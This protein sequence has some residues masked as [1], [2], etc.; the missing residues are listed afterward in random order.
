LIS[1]KRGQFKIST[2]DGESSKV[3]KRGWLK[4][5]KGE[6]YETGE[7]A[8]HRAHRG[9]KHSRS[10]KTGVRRQNTRSNA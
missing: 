4:V 6:L 10:Q 7:E 8:N 2:G 3:G 9:N 5:K 1:E